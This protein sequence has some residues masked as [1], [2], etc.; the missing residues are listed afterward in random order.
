VGR[1][2]PSRNAL[3][4]VDRRLAW[5][6][7]L[8]VVAS[9]CLESTPPAEPPVIAW[10]TAHPSTASPGDPVT[11][12][13]NVS[14]AVSLTL[15]PGAVDVTGL[16]ETTVEPAATTTYVL[17]ASNPYGSASRQVEVRV[18][19]APQ[20][21]AFGPDAGLVNAGRSATLRWAVEAAE[22]VALRG[23]GLGEGVPVSESSGFRVTDVPAGATYTLVATNDFGTVEGR[24]EVGRS[25]PAVSLL[26]AGQ[27][28]AVGTNLKP[29]EALGFVA[30]AEGVQMLGNDDVWKPAYEPLDDCA[31][32]VDAVSLDACDPGG[33]GPGVSFGV[34]AGNWTRAL[35]GGEVFLIPAAKGGSSA[36]AWQPAADRYDRTTLFG[37]AA[38]RA[39]LAG[40]ERGAPVGYE[41]EGAAYGGVLWFQ[42]ETDSS[43]LSRTIG[44]R[45][46]T[47]AVFDAF[48]SELGAPIIYAQLARRGPVDGDPDPTT[49]NLLY[50]RVRDE[51]R[52][53]ETG[54]REVDGSVS[55][56]AE[57][58]RFMVVTHDLPMHPGDGRH[59]SAEG[60]VELGRRMTLALRE[61]LRGEDVDGSGPRLVEV[62]RSSDTQLR[63]RAD[64]PVTAPAT[65][66]AL[67]YSGY[68]GVFSAGS[69]LGVTR[70]E[71]DPDDPTTVLITLQEPSAGGVE[72]RYMPPPGILAAFEADVIRSASC[73]DGM[74][75]TGAC[76]PM[77]AFGV[78]ADAAS[79]E[80]L[81]RYAVEDPR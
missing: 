7:V 16:S 57:P 52:R 71:R 42:G 31:D 64:R 48:E 10:V 40:L 61:H 19:D 36:D 13:W 79:R 74:P 54:A 18:G 25:V 70:I 76:L 77:P 12:A 9:S 21:L 62:V 68:F 1:K 15:D 66:D 69:P 32:Q 41:A 49:R 67:A 27:S 51:Q 14:G 60:Q 81:W 63:M 35:T 28:N 43:R 37:N 6:W 3:P 50:Q 24:A 44:F 45:S 78:A 73:S 38:H 80:A 59:L 23:P 58:R 56:V 17:V 75:G 33:D 34:S 8:A 4:R 22:T 20:I 39:T 72:V 11:L 26:I 30:A 29:A 46:K 47:D 53:M 65:T 2:T 5:V 55:S